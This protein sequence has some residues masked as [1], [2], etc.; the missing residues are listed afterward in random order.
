MTGRLACAGHSSGRALL[1][2]GREAGPRRRHAH[3][4]GDHR[5]PC[6]RARRG[7][8]EAGTLVMVLGTSS[9]HM[10]NATSE[11]HIP[12]VAG[13]VRD[14]ILPGLVGYETGQAA[15]GDLFDWFRRLAGETDF[16]RLDREAAAIGPCAEGVL[17]LDWVNGCRTPLMNG[18]L[19]GCFAGLSLYHTP[20]HLYRAAI[21]ATAFGTAVDR[22]IAPRA[23]CADPAMRRH[24]RP[25]A[26]QSALGADLCRRARRADPYRRRQAWTGPGRRDSGRPG[27]RRAKRI[28][29]RPP[30]RSV[31]WRAD[32]AV[33]SA[34][35]GR[36][37]TPTRPMRMFISTIV[38]WPAKCKAYWRSTATRRFSGSSE[39]R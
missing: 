23:R 30:R 26:P 12:G 37:P 39:N 38:S 3:Q 13:V 19:R 14:G 22:R 20:A 34:L 31:R 18:D 29:P 6:R 5:R 33:L 2:G 9:C 1:G 7:A 36:R 17:C 8:A 25:A 16:E 27:R 32:R 35:C 15:V 10:L 11:Q 21:E 28:R 24:R 4:R